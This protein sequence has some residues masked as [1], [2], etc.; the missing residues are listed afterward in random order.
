[1]GFASKEIAKIPAN[2]VLLK[3]IS[4]V[5]VFWG[6]FAKGNKGFTLDSIHKINEFY[7]NKLINISKPTLYSFEE[8]RLAFDAIK[9]RKS[10]GKLSIYTSKYDMDKN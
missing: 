3:N 8:Y 6:P 5:G 9:K 2:I 4:V 1:M 7:E 10:V